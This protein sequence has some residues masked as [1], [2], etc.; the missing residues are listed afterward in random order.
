MAKKNRT[1]QDEAKGGNFISEWFG[2]RMYPQVVGTRESVADQRAQRCPFLFIATGEHRACI[3]PNTSKGVCTSNSASNG[4]RPDWGVCP[5]RA[6][7]QAL[8]HAVARRLFGMDGFEMFPA[9]V[10]AEEPRQEQ[11]LQLLHAGHSVLVYF[12]Q[13]KWAEKSAYRPRADH[14]RSP[15]TLRLLS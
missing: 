8:F 15:S 7:D 11:V 9:P 5:Y 3:K 1:E 10:L 13:K 4:Q 14:P 12:D 6:F 2:H